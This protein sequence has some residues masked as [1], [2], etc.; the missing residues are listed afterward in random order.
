M[1]L[2]SFNALPASCRCRLFMCEVFFFGTARSTPSQMSVNK[3]GMFKDIA[4]ID[5]VAAEYSE[6]EKH[7]RIG[8]EA[9]WKA[10]W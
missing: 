5:M 7:R 3:P 4:G 10:V 9:V 8:L 6:L 1:L 2:T